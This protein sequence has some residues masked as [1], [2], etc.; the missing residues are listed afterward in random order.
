MF[1]MYLDDRTLGGSL[2]DV[3]SDLRSIDRR[4]NQPWP[5]GKSELI[6]D[7]I[8]TREAVLSE[9]PGHKAAL[10]LKPLFFVK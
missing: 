8:L 4:S 5:H 1:Y 7:D 10:D 6:C 9:D 3:C 2:Q